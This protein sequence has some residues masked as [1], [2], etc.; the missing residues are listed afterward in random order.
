VNTDAV[1]N[2]RLRTHRYRLDA[3]QGLPANIRLATTRTVE[4]LNVGHYLSPTPQ[5]TLALRSSASAL[6]RVTFVR[7]WL[8][9]A[10]AAASNADAR[11]VSLTLLYR[12]GMAA[13]GGRRSA[14]RCIA[15]WCAV[16]LL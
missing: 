15:H 3:T 12:R 14:S 11:L 6:F 9:L 13:D 8:A 1:T 10:A 16:S 5:L 7:R 4:I 2:E